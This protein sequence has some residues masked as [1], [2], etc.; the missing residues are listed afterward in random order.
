MLKRQRAS[1]PPPTAHYDEEPG[2]PSDP[3]VIPNAKKRRTTAPLLSVEHRGWG[4]TSSTEDLYDSEDDASDEETVTRSEPAPYPT[5]KRVVD[6]GADYTTTNTLLH[7]LHLRHLRRLGTNDNGLSGRQDSFTS[8]PAPSAQLEP[9]PAPRLR[10][11]DIMHKAV[12]TLY[13]PIP[14]H[15]LRGK[16]MPFNDELP[17]MGTYENLNKY[18]SCLFTACSTFISACRL[19][20]ALVLRRRGEVCTADDETTEASK[21]VRPDNIRTSAYDSR[22]LCCLVDV[23]GL[24]LPLSLFRSRVLSLPRIVLYRITLAPPHTSF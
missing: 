1:S 22:T 11:L 5:T 8:S 19:L 16:E 6:A 18:V 20:G 15:G 24:S 23:L 7:D 10:S 3:P 4:R 2:P 9:S 13:E 14:V 21:T 17:G 12:P